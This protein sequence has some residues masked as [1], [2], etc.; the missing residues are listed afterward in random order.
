MSLFDN[1]KIEELTIDQL[2]TLIQN[3]KEE[4]DQLTKEIESLRNDI[5]D[6]QKEHHEKLISLEK[7]YDNVLS[8]IEKE[9]IKL[10]K[11]IQQLE[12]K[13]LVLKNNYELEKNELNGKIEVLKQ[14]RSEL[15]KQK[16]K[17][18]DEAFEK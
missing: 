11:N 14:Q 13:Q 4:I 12:N 7:K 9:N 8:K 5:D 10:T 6:A 3:K 16:K 1:K 2:G 18:D 17:M 15:V